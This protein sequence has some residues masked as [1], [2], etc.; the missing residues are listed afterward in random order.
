MCPAARWCL[1]KTVSRS[2]SGFSKVCCRVENRFVFHCV[3]VSAAGTYM[4]LWI[5]WLVG[6]LVVFNLTV[7]CDTLA[8]WLTCWFVGSEV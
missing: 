2:V 4:V 6:W 1:G 7:I 5:T 8:D 3:F